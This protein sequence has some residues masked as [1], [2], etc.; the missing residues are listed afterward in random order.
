MHFQVGYTQY[1]W[2]IPR[3]RKK[4]SIGD[5]KLFPY[6]REVALYSP[7]PISNLTIH[8]MCDCNWEKGCLKF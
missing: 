2:I 4:L 1:P 3:D 6:L 5:R 7:K 8:R